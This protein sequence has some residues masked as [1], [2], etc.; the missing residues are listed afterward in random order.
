MKVSLFPPLLLAVALLFAISSCDDDCLEPMNFTAIEMG[1]LGGGLNDNMGIAWDWDSNLMTVLPTKSGNTYT[2]LFP[3]IQMNASNNGFK[4]REA[5]MWTGIIIGY[6]DVVISGDGAM[7]I[8]SLSPQND[9]F[10]V[11]Q[12]SNGYD[13]YLSVDACTMEWSLMVIKL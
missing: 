7:D 11:T 12:D 5:D 13:F 9:T 8:T 2:W 6:Y 10:T 3:G 1:I 4:F